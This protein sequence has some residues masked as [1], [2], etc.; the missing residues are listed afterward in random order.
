MVLTVSFVLSPVIGLSCH[1]RLRSCLRKLDAGVEACGPPDFAVHLKRRSSAALSASTASRPA[2]M[3][4]RNA[5][6]WDRTAG[7]VKV[8]CPTPKAKYFCRQD[9]TA[10][11]PADEVICPSGKSERTFPCGTKDDEAFEQ[12]TSLLVRRGYVTATH[13]NQW[14]HAASLTA[15]KSS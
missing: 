4:L 15:S 7:V 2:L 3:T 5:P 1:R 13:A 11:N 12:E 10:A 6:L 14:P 8:I 9:W